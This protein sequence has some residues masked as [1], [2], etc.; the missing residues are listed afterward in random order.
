MQ[1]TAT[2]THTHAQHA[3][4][5]PQ[6]LKL[7]QRHTQTRTHAQTHSG[8]IF[9]GVHSLSSSII[10]ISGEGGCLSV[11]LCTGPLHQPSEAPLPKHTTGSHACTR[12]N[13]EKCLYDH[14][15]YPYMHTGAAQQW[16]HNFIP[17]FAPNVC[18]HTH[19]LPHTHCHLSQY[20]TTTTLQSRSDRPTHHDR[21][22]QSL[23]LLWVCVYEL[24]S[25]YFVL[26]TTARL[27]VC[28]CVCVGAYI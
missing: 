17:V 18:M 13:T 1:I 27:L 4:N 5:F 26:F 19:T 21:S 12:A 15:T 3:I 16:T 20:A 22:D 2:Q 25:D 14:P 11:P 6:K 23:C 10:H 9:Q 7:T 28:Q 8:V 24:F